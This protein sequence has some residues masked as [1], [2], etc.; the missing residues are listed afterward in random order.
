MS[1]AVAAA[2]ELGIRAS[3]V[4]AI[5]DDASAFYVRYGF[6]QSPPDPHNLQILV[7]DIRRSAEEAATPG[8][9]GAATDEVR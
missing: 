5:D 3:L 8:L 2:E 6:E 9:E 4:H 1:R 7:K